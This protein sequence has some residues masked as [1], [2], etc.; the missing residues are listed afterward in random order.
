MGNAFQSG[1]S[2]SAAAVAMGLCG[3]LALTLLRKA[4][5]PADQAGNG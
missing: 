2:W 5:M 3:A 4:G 1:L